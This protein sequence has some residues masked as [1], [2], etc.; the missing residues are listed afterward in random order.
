MK[1]AR[2]LALVF[3]IAI[4]FGAYAAS[5]QTYNLTLCGASPGGLWTLLGAGI[6]AA[7]K[8]SFPGST[9]TY[10]TSGGG[11]AN[12]GLL[13]DRKCDIALIHNAEAKAA[14]AG[15]P[16]FKAPVDTLATVA[17]LYT[18]APIQII[19][20]KEYVEKNG[21]TALKDIAAKKL[22]VRIVLNKRGNIASAVGESLMIAAGLNQKDVES[23]GGSV[24]YAASNEQSDLMRDRRADVMINS[25][26]VNHSSISELASAIDLAIL[27]L[28]DATV[29]KVS[30][31][32][33]IDR[34]VIKAADYSWN[35]HDIQTVT[36]AAQLFTRMDADPKM[37]GDLT[38]A[39]VD[40]VE[41]LRSV[42]KAMSPLDV[43]LM[44]SAK[45]V[46]Y[47]PAAAAVFKAAGF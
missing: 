45:T 9:V 18:W 23:W 27:P 46:P 6:D 10:Q 3:G 17:Q 4:T 38:K 34:Y 21:L 39:L 29:E 13:N 33:D 24:T 47:H 44:A 31:E 15:M 35:D 12:V 26:F 30:Q 25:L 40:N 14:I 2:M 36:I 28:V 32:W 43:K 20:P 16:P 19:A 42:H 8:K 37:V 11:L 5:A 41:E 1:T 22:P 7:V